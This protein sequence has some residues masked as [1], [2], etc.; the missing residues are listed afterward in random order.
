MG[1]QL[2]YPK[3]G[4]P[5]IGPCLLWPNGW[6]DQDATWYKGRPRPRPHCVTRRPSSPSQ[7]RHTFPIFGPCLL[8]PNGR[9][10]QLLL[11]IRINRYETELRHSVRKPTAVRSRS[12]S[13]I[14]DGCASLCSSLWWTV[15]RVMSVEIL[16]SVVQLYENS[17]FKRPAIAA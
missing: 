17:H 10:S 12:S 1:T 3:K 16:S 7:K 8:W 11:S 9:P 2:P 14:F 6:M 15:R 4:P 5:I 13:N